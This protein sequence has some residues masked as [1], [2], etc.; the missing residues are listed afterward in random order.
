MVLVLPGSVDDG[1]LSND[2]TEYKL[3]YLRQGHDP[4]YVMRPGDDNLFGDEITIGPGGEE[5]P[6]AR[7]FS[8]Y[9]LT[10]QDFLDSPKSRSGARYEDVGYK[11]GAFTQYPTQAGAHFRWA[12]TEGVKAYNPAGA[13]AYPEDVNTVTD[14]WDTISQDYESCPPGYR[15]PADGMTWGL[16][17]SVSPDYSEVHQSLMLSPTTGTTSSNNNSVWGYYADGFF[18]R[19]APRTESAAYNTVTNSVV[20]VGRSTQAYLGHL[21]YNPTSMASVFL[22][23]AGMRFGGPDGGYDGRL[24]NPGRYGYYWTASPQTDTRAWGLYISPTGA[25]RS[26]GGAEVYNVHNVGMLIRC[27]VEPEIEPLHGVCASGSDR[28]QA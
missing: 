8:P 1:D 14:D 13:V 19:R 2:P 3:L 27:V 21:F 12:H 10:A 6:L 25:S 26:N 17:A 22:P 5:R 11:G 4:D 18:D 23:A 20:G 28:D 16:N 24:V 7:K 15:R 9:N